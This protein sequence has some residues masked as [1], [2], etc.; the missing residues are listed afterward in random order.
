MHKAKGFTLIELIAVIVI[1]G[2]LAVTAIPQFL[3]LRNNAREAAAG[4][5]GG[6]I[7]SASAL[8]YARGVA[9]GGASTVTACTGTALGP[10]VNA[11]AT[12]AGTLTMNGVVY[13]V[14]STTAPATSG[15]SGVC[16][17][18][19]PSGG[20]AQSFNVIGCANATCS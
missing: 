19:H 4:G 15:A 16:T 7:A 14:G 2:I 18:T 1:L 20:A 8:N 13:N 9:Q 12:A 11:S 10:L 6:A 17:L 3:D 5:I